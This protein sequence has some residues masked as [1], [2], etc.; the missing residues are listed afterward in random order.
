MIVNDFMA[1]DKNIQKFTSSKKAGSLL[2]KGN[3]N[4]ADVLYSNIVDESENISDSPVDF[5][6]QSKI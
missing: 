4:L 6:P 5:H 2:Y 1:S 3:W